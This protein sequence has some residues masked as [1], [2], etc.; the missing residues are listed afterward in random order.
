MSDNIQKAESTLKC[1]RCGHAVP[2]PAESTS[3]DTLIVCPACGANLGRWGDTK[4][5]IG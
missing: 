3:D 5:E 1:T 4:K 2:L